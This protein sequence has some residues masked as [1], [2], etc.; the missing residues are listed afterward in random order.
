MLKSSSLS[1]L[2]VAFDVAVTLTRY[3]LPIGRFAGIGQVNVPSLS[4][5]KPIC[6][7]NRPLKNKS[8]FTVD[9]TSGLEVQSICLVVSNIQ[10]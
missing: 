3:V 1:S 2:I 5:L 8:M 7:K 10:T 9:V 4:S 6:L